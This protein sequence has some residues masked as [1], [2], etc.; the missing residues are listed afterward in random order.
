MQAISRI[1]KEWAAGVSA[2]DEA[3]NIMVVGQDNGD[4]SFADIFSAGILACMENTIENV[5]EENTDYMET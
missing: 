4:S 1:K 5:I 3:Y 2:A